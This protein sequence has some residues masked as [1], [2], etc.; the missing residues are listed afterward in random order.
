MGCKQRTS[1]VFVKAIGSI[2][3]VHIVLE[4]LKPA[5]SEIDPP[6]TGLSVLEFRP[7]LDS[8][9]QPNSVVFWFE[10]V[11]IQRVD[12]ASSHPSTP[13]QCNERVF[14]TRVLIL[15]VVGQRLLG[16][17]SGEEHVAGFCTIWEFR[18]VN[19]L[20]EPVVDGFD[21]S[22]PAERHAKAAQL[23]LERDRS[24]LVSTPCNKVSQIA[25][26][27]IVEVVDTSQIAPLKKVVESRAGVF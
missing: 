19:L 7:A 27:E 2:G 22:P 17:F 4:Y 25:S 5:G 14:S 13:Q 1:T 11:H 23:F 26:S 20:G 15:I 6:F 18:C 24:D 3:I 9:L 12:R 10:I 21:I 8:V 16:T